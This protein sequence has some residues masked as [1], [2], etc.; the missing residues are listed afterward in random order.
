[1]ADALRLEGEAI[2]GETAIMSIPRWSI[3]GAWALG[4][5]LGGCNVG[6]SPGGGPTGAAGTSGGTGAAGDGATGMTTDA[7]ASGRQACLEKINGFRATLSLAPLTRWTAQEACSDAAAKSDSETGKGHG[8]FG[9]CTESA[10]N[11]CP[12]WKS[13]ASITAGGGCLDDMWSEGPGA[14]FATHGHYLNMSNTKYTRVAC[15]FHV[16]PDGHVWAVQNFR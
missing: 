15:G 8:A 11:E 13:V 6:A 4:A 12:N 5:L 14:D 10:Q 1:V 16:T 9:A 2:E 3:V 7:L